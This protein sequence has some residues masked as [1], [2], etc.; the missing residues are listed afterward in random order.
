[1]LDPDDAGATPTTKLNNPPKLI[2]VKRTLVTT[3][4]GGV[5]CPRRASSD[6]REEAY[7]N[8]ASYKHAPPLQF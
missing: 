1:V 6:R 2:G 8:G 3:S 4:T 5:G 7:A